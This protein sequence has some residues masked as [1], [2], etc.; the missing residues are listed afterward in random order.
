MSLTAEQQQ[1]LDFF[2]AWQRIEDSLPAL[3]ELVVVKTAAGSMDWDWLEPLGDRK[4]F[5][6]NFGRTA[7]WMSEADFH[8]LAPRGVAEHLRPLDEEYNTRRLERFQMSTGVAK[9]VLEYAPNCVDAVGELDVSLVDPDD[10]DR[11]LAAM[12]ATPL[13]VLE[14]PTSWPTIECSLPEQ[15]LAVGFDH[16]NA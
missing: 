8:R 13:L 14:A 16:P 12:E 11:Q 9:A 7:F 15:P 5:A 3:F 2:A 6:E 1:E 10:L 4:Y